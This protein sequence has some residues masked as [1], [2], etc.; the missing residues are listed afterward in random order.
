MNLELLLQVPIAVSMQY[1]YGFQSAA[2]GTGDLI[3]DVGYSG[4]MF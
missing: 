1:Q 3:I 2:G 4:A